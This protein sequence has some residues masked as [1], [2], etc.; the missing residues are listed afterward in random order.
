M[1]R[2]GH[3]DREQR[4]PTE[5]DGFQKGTSEGASGMEEA[6]TQL[7][8]GREEVFPGRCRRERY[9]PRTEIYDGLGTQE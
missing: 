1:S 2:D 8:F 6:A 4:G 3:A 7:N 9:Q 5:G